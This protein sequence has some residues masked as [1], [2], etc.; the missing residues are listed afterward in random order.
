MRR[1]WM[2]YGGIELLFHY[3]QLRRR[4]YRQLV[5]FHRRKGPH[6]LHRLSSRTSH[7]R[8]LKRTGSCSFSRRLCHQQL[9]AKS[10]SVSPRREVLDILDDLNSVLNKQCTSTRKVMTCWRSTNIARFPANRL[11]LR[12][13]DSQPN[14]AP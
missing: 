4:Q 6:H 7:R 10:D 2:P 5:I 14:F 3:L 13:F 12:N 8:K 11:N 1:Q 9:A